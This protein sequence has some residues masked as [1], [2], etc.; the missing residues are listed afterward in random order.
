[1]GFFEDRKEQILQRIELAMG[2]KIAR[3]SNVLD[4]SYTVATT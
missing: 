2:K 1:M 4:V 3:D